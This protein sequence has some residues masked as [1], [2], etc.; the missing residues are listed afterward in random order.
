M[1]RCIHCETISCSRE[2]P[3]KRNL[4]FCQAE[5]CNRLAWQT[6][7][8]YCDLHYVKAVTF[9]RGYYER[10][11]Y[12]DQAGSVPKV[13]V[14]QLE[15][16]HQ[17]LMRKRF[18]IHDFGTRQCFD[19]FQN[20]TTEAPN[21]FTIDTEFHLKRDGTG[22]I[23]TEVAIVNVR[24]ARMVVH[25]ILHPMRTNVF[26]KLKNLTA[27]YKAHNTEISG[28]V[29]TAL[30]VDELVQ[31]LKDAQF[32]PN[33]WIIEYSTQKGTL[34][35]K[36]LHN[37]LE[38]YG[39]NAQKLVPA[40]HTASIYPTAVQLL[41]KPLE[42]NCAKQP[43]L[44]R[45]LFPS[46]PLVD[47]NHSA[48]IDAMQLI[49]IFKLMAALLEPPEKRQLPTTLFQGL[50]E[51]FKRDLHCQDS[52]LDKFFTSLDSPR[53][54]IETYSETLHETDESYS[55]VNEFNP[56]LP[57][58]LSEDEDEEEEGASTGRNNR[59]VYKKI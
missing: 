46:D 15:T 34:D 52:T 28:H 55:H 30:T 33:D 1:P 17:R 5:N 4:A 25:A 23:T 48:V 29:R 58:S 8:V 59:S 56:I 49:Q 35:V 9:F 40:K 14:N 3:I 32:T 54:V 53:S 19:A 43:F 2:L 13:L 24:T 44:F 22:R 37:L 20:R 16:M 12:G 10:Y 50:D 27:H 6:V 39:Y 38:S 42:L 21:V 51:L 7:G 47:L 41:K 31:Q 45:I 18:Q 26:W 11:L 36:N 57:E